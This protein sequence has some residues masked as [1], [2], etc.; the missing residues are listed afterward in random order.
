[1]Y[2]L[3]IYYVYIIYIYY[4]YYIY[5][6]NSGMTIY[7]FNLHYIFIYNII[8]IL[9]I[10]CTQRGE[11]ALITALE[12]RHRDIATQL[13]SNTNIDVNIISEVTLII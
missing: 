2:I 7:N 11:V 12:H 1:M 3:Y 10:Y 5:I 4:I 8:C 13:L 6:Y 9:Y